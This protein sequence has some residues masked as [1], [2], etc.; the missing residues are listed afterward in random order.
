VIEPGAKKQK[1]VSVEKI[2]N[3]TFMANPFSIQVGAFLNEAKATAMRD[4][5]AGL[6]DKQVIIVPEGAYFKVRIIGFTS[7]E[8]MEKYRPKLIDIGLNQTW[9]IPAKKG[10]EQIPVIQQPVVEEKRGMVKPG[11]ALQVGVFHS[12]GQALSAQRKITSR[13]SLPVEIVEQWDYYSVIITG[14]YTREETYKYYPQLAELGFS[15]ISLI[16]N[17]K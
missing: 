11:I 16:I 1:P 5:I 12:R 8:E 6:I 2:E 7:T 3:K 9:L 10:E 13:L 15:Q 4:K 14:F 17:K